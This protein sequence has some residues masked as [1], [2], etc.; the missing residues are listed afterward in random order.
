MNKSFLVEKDG[1]RKWYVIR[2][3]AHDTQY[4]MGDK[5]PRLGRVCLIRED[6]T[7]GEAETIQGGE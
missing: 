2:Q 3:M 6:M 5:I 1:K 7:I 4:K